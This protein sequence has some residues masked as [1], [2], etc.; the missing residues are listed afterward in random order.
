MGVEGGMDHLTTSYSPSLIEPLIRA[1]RSS[2]CD[3]DGPFVL[4]PLDP[5]SW[6]ALYIH[7]RSLLLPSCPKFKAGDQIKTLMR[8]LYFSQNQIYLMLVFFFV[9]FSI[10]NVNLFSFFSCPMRIYLCTCPKSDKI[11]TTTGFVSTHFPLF[12]SFSKQTAYSSFTIT[13]FIYL[14]IS[15]IDHKVINASS[16][17]SW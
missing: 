4:F 7:S 14:F 16:H 17:I 6:I 2:I 5:F 9:L 15:Y 1:L 11:C 3:W 10:A 8:P 12:V 13:S